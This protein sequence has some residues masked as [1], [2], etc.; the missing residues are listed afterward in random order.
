MKVE[1]YV[2]DLCQLPSDEKQDELKLEQA[3]VKIC[4]VC[5]TVK[6]LHDFYSKHKDLDSTCKT[7]RCVQRKKRY[8][9]SPK[10]VCIES[11]FDSQ[12][13]TKEI[14]NE[15][16][17]LTSEDIK[18]IAEAMLILEGWQIDLDTQRDLSNSNLMSSNKQ[19]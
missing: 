13:S 17:L 4:S 5:K 12:P 9:A 7:C 3:N 18:K 10:K 1:N 16:C 14:F 15:P 6:P 8:K 19:K 11:S 2:G